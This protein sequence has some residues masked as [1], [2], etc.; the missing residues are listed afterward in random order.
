MTSL[1]PKCHRPFTKEVVK[2]EV[3]KNSI[4]SALR[5]PIIGTQSRPCYVD[6]TNAVVETKSH[7]RCKHCGHE[8]TENKTVELN[9]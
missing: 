2:S 9:A 7:Y 1:C 4:S 3:M 8:W 5:A 6:V